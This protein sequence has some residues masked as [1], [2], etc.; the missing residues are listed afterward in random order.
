M[1]R[2]HVFITVAEARL[3]GHMQSVFFTRS[4]ESDVLVNVLDVFCCIYIMSVLVQCIVS[5]MSM[6]VFYSYRKPTAGYS[7]KV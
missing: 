2:T 6:G 5:F 3:Y 4:L 1:D 7:V